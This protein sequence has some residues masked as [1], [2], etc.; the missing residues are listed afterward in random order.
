MQILKP[1]QG[2]IDWQ[3]IYVGSADSYEYDQI[4]GV[5]N[6]PGGTANE[7]QFDWAINAPD[8]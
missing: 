5:I 1:L 8:Y 4:L 3:V 6:V 2:T 7:I